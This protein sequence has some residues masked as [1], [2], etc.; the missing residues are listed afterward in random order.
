MVRHL[1]CAAAA[2]AAVSSASALGSH[3]AMSANPIRR[4]VNLLQK[5]QKK[6]AE[7]AKRDK[8]LFDKYMCYCTTGNGDLER[9]IK[10]AETKMP[11]VTSGL[12][13]AKAK[14]EQL[15]SDLKAHGGDRADAQDALEKA[16]A[17]REKEAADFAKEESDTKANLGA[18]G[19]AIT[20]IEKGASGGFLQTQTAAVVRK[21]VVDMDLTSGDRDTL[22]SFLTTGQQQS[23]NSDYAPAS[24]EITGI[25]KQMHDTMASS[26]KDLQKSEAESTSSFKALSSAKEKEISVNTRMIESKTARLGQT[27]VEIENLREDLDDTSASY[28]EDKDFL[29]NLDKNCATKKKEWDA[30]QKTRAKEMVALADTIKILN[31]DNALDLF[32][33]TLA[34]PS[35]LQLKVQAKTLRM[36]ALRVLKA[37]QHSKKTGDPRLDFLMLAI[38][39][40]KVSFDKV[41]GMVD[42]MTKVLKREQV[43]DDSKK[44]YCEERLDESEDEQKSLTLSVSDLG[45]TIEETKSAIETLGKEIDALSVGI[46]DLDK[47]VGEATETRKQENAE[48]KKV[49]ASN[50]AAK[51]LMKMAKNKL[52]QFYNP[53]LALAQA[54]K[55]E[56][57]A[58]FVQVQMHSRRGAPPPPPEA[59]GAYQNKGEESAGVLSMIDMLIAD[60]DKEMTEM[61]VEEKDSQSDYEKYI[62]DSK[63][64]RA[65]D[66]KLV[67]EKE[68]MK[69]EAE[70]LLQKSHLE[71]KSKEKEAYANSKV[72]RDLHQECDWLLQNFGVRKEARAGN[73]DSLDKAKAILSGADYS[74]VQEGSRRSRITSH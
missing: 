62:G 60:L 28:S 1:L 6:V 64:K 18:M 63:T 52:N 41:I 48:Y 11:Q 9:S 40:K 13:E 72:I 22:S 49:M 30:V 16:T 44:S 33:K 55:K 32:K 61:E 19:K 37:R 42:E 53:K 12:A 47:S 58:S 71:K 43:D 15:Q 17:I 65:I 38:R 34:S 69:A 70:A 67:E 10:A 31:D 3:T 68:G 74:L 25:L 36:Q 24:G 59:V 51:E 66:S 35:L 8:E 2:A 5:M 46:T 4:V 26:L 56:E 20:A 23:E 14:K 54:D 45:K 27:G 57:A 39:G 21:L 73:I 50:A 29:V 7:E